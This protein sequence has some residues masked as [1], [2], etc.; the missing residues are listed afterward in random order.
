MPLTHTRTFRVRGYECD[1][2]GHV[3]HANY[4]RWAQEAAFDASAAAGYDVQRYLDL[5]TTWLIR[6]TKIDYLRPVRYG[7]SVDVKTWVAD[8]RRVRSRRAYEFRL[9][10]AEPLVARAS[11]DW[12]YLDRCTLRPVTIPQEMKFGFFPEGPPQ[13]SPARQ[14]FP[15]PPA[16]PPDVFIQRR[17]AEWRDLDEAGHVNNAVYL[18]YI[19]D[20]GQQMVAALGW[21]LDR[22][23]AEGSAVV[24]RQHRIEYKLPALLDDELELRTWLSDV[25]GSTATRHTT[26]T[27]ASDDTLLQRART[28]HVWI[29]LASGRP[30]DL[31]AAF[32][33]ALAPAITQDERAGQAQ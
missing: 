30:A 19:E 31:P 24:A 9:T 6:E 14:R 16:P 32:L 12:V 2:Y 1:A 28:V 17:R 22:M 5:G 4:M 11:T 13:E 29:D 26:I 33:T 7:D 3:N 23:T 25:Q 21:P 15:A 8:F 27:R 10:G 18:S 20:C